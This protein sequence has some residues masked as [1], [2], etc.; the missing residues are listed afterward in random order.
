VTQD[1]VEYEILEGDIGYVLLYDFF[2]SAMEGVDAALGYFEEQKV[3]GIIFDVRDNPG[4]LLDYCIGITD[5]FVDGGVI[6]YTE[7]RNG[8]REY[9]NATEGR[10]ELPLAVLTNKDSA[11]ASEIFAAAIQEAGTGVIVG[12]TTYGK[13]I[14]QTLYQFYSDGAGMQLTTSAYYTQSG[15]SIHKSGVTPDLAV[16]E[17]EEGDSQL[18]AALRLLWEQ[19]GY[20]PES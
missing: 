17:S 16:E 3:K 6:V 7:D 18:E 2:G 10:I 9:Y 20:E 19:T 4:G 1:R 15:K 13:G 12:E 14:V 8:E 11:S 5:H